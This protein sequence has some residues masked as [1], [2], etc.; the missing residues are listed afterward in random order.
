MSE[1]NKDRAASQFAQQADAKQTGIVGEMFAFFR[2]TRKWWLAPA[3][4]LLLLVGLLVVFGGTSVA[5][6]IYTLF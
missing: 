4:L 3:V 5:P 2:Y 1:T 6:F